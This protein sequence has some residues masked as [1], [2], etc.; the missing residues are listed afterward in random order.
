MRIRF[1][2]LRELENTE[3]NKKDKIV[4]VWCRKH[5]RK[6]G[7]LLAIFNHRQEKARWLETHIWHAKR[8]K[9]EEL[10]G[11][12]IAAKN[13]DKSERAVYRYVGQA[14]CCI[15]DQSYF[16]VFNVTK[17]DAIKVG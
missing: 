1:R 7:K 13:C 17:T 4:R 12:K 11:T 9:M 5:R 3:A 2:A 8:F 15:H 10:W 6:P 16:R 14:G